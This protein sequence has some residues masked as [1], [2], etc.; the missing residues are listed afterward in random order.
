MRVLVVAAHPDDEILGCGSTDGTTRPRRSRSTP[1]SC[2][3]MSSRYAHREDADPGA[4]MRQSRLPVRQRMNLPLVLGLSVNLLLAQHPI[5]CL[6]QMTRH[7]RG[8]LPVHL[9]A[10]LHTLVQ[11][12]D[13]PVSPVSRTFV[14]PFP[15]RALPRHRRHSGVTHQTIGSAEP[16]HVSNLQR[17]HRTQNFP[18]ARQTVADPAPGSDTVFLPRSART[19]R[20]ASPPNL[21]GGSSPR[22]A[23]SFTLPP[24]P[25]K[26]DT[27]MSTL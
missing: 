22:R 8:C 24:S 9:S 10:L 4:A 20:S 25:K 5:G 14:F 12:H 26:S 11:L 16:P 2:E 7:C 15:V 3:G 21:C 13:M 19:R 6:G 17:H 27:A 23:S 1:P 18:Y